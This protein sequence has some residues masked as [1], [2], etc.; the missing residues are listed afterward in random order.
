[1][2]IIAN[3]KRD[4]VLSF[5]KNGKPIKKSD[6]G[7]LKYWAPPHEAFARPRIMPPIA[8]CN[9]AGAFKCAC[10]CFTE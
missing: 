2:N 9:N 1:V 7:I 3:I 10:V 6:K 8:A 5:L 4:L